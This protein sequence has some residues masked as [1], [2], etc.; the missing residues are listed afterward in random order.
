[1]LKRRVLDAIRLV[2]QDDDALDLEAS[3]YD[4]YLEEGCDWQHLTMA[5]G[6][7][8]TVF[9]VQP[10]THRQR[11]AMSRL[12]EGFEQTAFMVRCGLVNVENFE[13]SRDGKPTVLGAPKRARYGDAGEIVS[14]DWLQDAGFTMN[15]YGA[16][17]LAI[18]AISEAQIPLLKRLGDRATETE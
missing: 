14:E 13:V 5:N 10:I 11:I 15:E 17:A 4:K 12:D 1:M 16:L 3:K 8:P 2:L 9:V 7:K 6:T 18:T